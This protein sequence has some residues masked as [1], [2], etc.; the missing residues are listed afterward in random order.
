M[1]NIESEKIEDWGEPSEVHQIEIDPHGNN[2]ERTKSDD[3]YVEVNG[4][5]VANWRGTSG[6]CD[7]SRVDNEW[8][9]AVN[10]FVEKQKVAHPTLS[11]VTHGWGQATGECRKWEDWPDG[12]RCNGSLSGGVTVY[13]WNAE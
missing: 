8:Q 2:A 5:V 9:S 3:A 1:E 13:F 12:R 6:C 11:Y 10:A 7:Q 4:S